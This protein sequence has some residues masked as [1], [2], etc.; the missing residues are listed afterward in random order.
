MG[1]CLR[2]QRGRRTDVL[3]C[4]RHPGDL[5][6]HVNLGCLNVLHGFTLWTLGNRNRSVILR[7]QGLSE[8]DYV[9]TGLGCEMFLPVWEIIAC[10]AIEN[11]SARS[12][13]MSDSWENCCQVPELFSNAG[14]KFPVGP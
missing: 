12:E 13:L 1:F 10:L 7:C 6:Q 3:V 2:K 9:A 5:L 4:L 14:H 11:N 8:C